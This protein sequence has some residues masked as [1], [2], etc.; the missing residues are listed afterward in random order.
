MFK[1]IAIGAIALVTLPFLSRNY[2]RGFKH[3]WN[4]ELARQ[5]RLG[6]ETKFARPFKNV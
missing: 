2:R 4:E 3:G 1:K 5:Q 6:N